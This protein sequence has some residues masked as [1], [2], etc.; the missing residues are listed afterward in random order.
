MTAV[1]IYANI[2]KLSLA[3][4]SPSSTF[5]GSKNSYVLWASS[6]CLF[7]VFRNMIS[8]CSFVIE[9]ALVHQADLKLRDMPVG[10]IF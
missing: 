4:E 1:L 8:L 3:L 10:L 2:F 5:W 9:L 7:F 6:S